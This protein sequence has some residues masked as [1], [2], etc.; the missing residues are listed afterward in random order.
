MPTSPPKETVLEA[1]DHQA[2]WKEIVQDPDLQDLPYH[3]ETNHRGH[4]VLSPHTAKHARQ[5]KAVQKRLD[6]LLDGGEAFSEWPVATDGGTKQIDVV[7]ASD[8][9][10]DAMTA[11]GDPPTM[12]PEICV[13]VMS[14]SNDGAEMNEKRTLYRTAGAEEVWVVDPD[15]QVHVF[16]DEELG[17]SQLAPGFPDRL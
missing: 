3:V 12:A 17:G 13:E 15:G 8:A 11:T 14:D 6:A 1:E 9:R 10:L 7:W 2:R 5:Q 4:I 16:A